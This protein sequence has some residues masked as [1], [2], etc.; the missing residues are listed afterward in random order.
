MKNRAIRVAYI[1]ASVE[2]TPEYRIRLE[3]RRNDAGELRWYNATDNQWLDS[4]DIQ[5]V[6]EAMATLIAW[7]DNPNSGWD[8]SV[9][10]VDEYPIIENKLSGYRYLIGRPLSAV[11]DV[12]YDR[13]PVVDHDGFITAI[14]EGDCIPEDAVL[15]D[16]FDEDGEPIVTDG[17]NGFTAV[18]DEN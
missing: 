4:H 3:L 7:Y 6:Q 12:M 18:L 16:G 15:I 11:P 2:N 5:T 13:W 17:M 10:E 1:T 14:L 9:G 8:L